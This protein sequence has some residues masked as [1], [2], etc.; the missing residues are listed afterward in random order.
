MCRA[1]PCGGSTVP[2][3]N[4]DPPP[5]EPQPS[6]H[7]RP[8]R[9]R[10]PTFGSPTRPRHRDAGPSP[11]CRP[12]A[13]HQP[14]AAHARPHQP[15]FPRDH[16]TRG[17]HSRELRQRPTPLLVTHQ[18]SGT[19]TTQ[20]TPDLRPAACAQG[21]PA[22]RTPRS[23]RTG[24]GWPTLQR[25]TAKYMAVLRAL[26]ADAAPGRTRPHPTAPAERFRATLAA[27]RS[28]IRRSCRAMLGHCA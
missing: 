11:C 6:D 22:R 26:T 5:A 21:H 12:R 23:P 8:H 1:R 16:R 15:R 17:W 9:L 28:R 13:E 19:L 25:H 4:R 18:P 20:S 7:R 3:T 2:G 27:D 24:G 10:R 14:C